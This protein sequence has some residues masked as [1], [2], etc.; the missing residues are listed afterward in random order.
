[1][2]S[3]LSRRSFALG[4]TAS[5][6]FALQ[7]S[8]GLDAVE[9]KGTVE[10]SPPTAP[11]IPTRYE[12]F[13]AVRIDRYDWL[14]D[15]EDSRVIG[16][17]EAENAYAKSRLEKI[18][19]LVDEIAAEL[20]AR[21]T[22][23]DRSVPATCNGYSYQ[24]RFKRGS[25]YPVIVRWENLN[26]A[27]RE[28]IVLDVAA[29]A[30][31]RPRQCELGSWIVSSNNK[32]IAFTVD[33]Q[34]NREYRIFVRSLPT[35]PVVD[36]GIENAASTI[37]FA[38]D[39]EILFYIR[40]EPQTV[41]SFQLWRHRVGSDATSDVLVYE[42][43]DPTFNI[44]LNLSK[45][46]KFLLL[47][48]EGEHTTEVRYLKVDSPTGPLK[49][50]EPRRRGVVYDVDHTSDT[51]FIRTNLDAPD[52]RLMS[53]PE[54]TPTLA[55]WIEF[56]PQELGHFLSRFEAFDSFVAVDIEDED[57]MKIRAFTFPAAREIPVPRPS[58]IGVASSSF[59]NDDQANLEATTTV[60]RFR[61]S[62][63]LQPESV[64]DFDV[65]SGT[66]TLRK[67]DPAIH[68]LD[69]KRYAI[70][71]IYAIAPDGEAV[72]ITAVYR[73]D[74][75]RRGGNPAL[76]LGYGAYGLSMRPT[77]TP[78][79]FSLLDRGFVYAIAHIRGG[80]EKGDRWYRLGRLL[81]KRNTFTDFIAA[82]ESLIAQGYADAQA[83]FAQGGSAGGLVMGT[84]ANLRP[85]LYTGIV[86]EAP[87]VDVITT[88]SDPSVPLTTLEYEE[89]GNPAVKR[90]YDYML[91]YSPYD[92]VAQK[93]YPA[94]FV[95]AGFYDSQVSYAE[96]AK[97]VARLRASKSDRRDLLLR[98]DMDS[99]H[100]G[101]SGRGG[102][103][104]Q[105]AEIIGWLIAQAP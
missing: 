104:R 71:R 35:G 98:T 69:S 68:W 5:S 44:S 18:T 3:L 37:V 25:R 41:R 60:L 36:E 53:A 16:Y 95:T 14:R 43:K 50:I 28:E 87:F 88:M 24:R 102:S 97:W 91:S 22:P 45:S 86:A 27:S 13:G 7:S 38:G 83:V 26:D 67:E 80:R 82:T 19:P 42:E 11:I 63:P 89:W 75:R 90:E 10:P 78:S 85:D 32:R 100:E 39:S 94:M 47:N 73:K 93:G 62:G 74:L 61:F 99:G 8:W 15:R 64:H 40:N 66:S 52:F 92:N 20:Q 105:N 72:P 17:L 51:F 57:G 59:E 70:D 58:G 55:Q 81:A 49:V 1:V 79:A 31:D 2:S 6:F 23:E 103:T 65:A 101:R 12:K 84:I 29:L 54:A 21:A 33:F 34:G 96:P 56:I 9:A 48:I 46:R 77:F 76:I 30:A 4:F